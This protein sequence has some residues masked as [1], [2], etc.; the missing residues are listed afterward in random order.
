MPQKK[1]AQLSGV[2]QKYMTIRGVSN[3]RSAAKFMFF[4]YDTL[5][6]RLKRPETFTLSE[7]SRVIK[8]L[9]IPASEIEFILEV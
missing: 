7:L 9:K 4:N 8:Y 2:I 6:R 1:T 3:V 5:R